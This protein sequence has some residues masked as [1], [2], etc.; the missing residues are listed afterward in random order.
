VVSGAAFNAKGTGRDFIVVV[1]VADYRRK[2]LKWW[3]VC[4]NV[5]T[6]IHC[7]LVVVRSRFVK[8]DDLLRIDGKVL[9]VGD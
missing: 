2:Q 3:N 8:V 4:C 7:L 6:A 1:S 9:K 5:V